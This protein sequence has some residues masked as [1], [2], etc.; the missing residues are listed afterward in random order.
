MTQEERSGNT[1]FENLMAAVGDGAGKAPGS[2]RVSGITSQGGDAVRRR[3]P[4]GDTLWQ[5]GVVKRWPF[6]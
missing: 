6:P 1:A 3:G 5:H 4:A 2:R